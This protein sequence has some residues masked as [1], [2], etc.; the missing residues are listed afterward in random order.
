MKKL[1]TL[2]PGVA[3]CSGDAAESEPEPGGGGSEEEEEAAGAPALLRPLSGRALLA[4]ICARPSPAGTALLHQDEEEKT[5]ALLARVFFFLNNDWGCRQ[6][7]GCGCRAARAV[8]GLLQFFF[9]C[10]RL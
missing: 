5:R 10:L 4:A 9:L 7:R 2:I 1:A 3:G 8:F 6:C